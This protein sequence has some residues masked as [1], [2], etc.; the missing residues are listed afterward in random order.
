MSKEFMM[1]Q[2]FLRYLFSRAAGSLIRTISWIGLLG[3]AIGVMSMVVV[4]NVM[5]GLGANMKERLLAVEPHLIFQPPSPSQQEALLTQLTEDLNL[6]AFVF[7]EQDILV[8]TSEGFFKGAIAKGMDM[9]PLKDMLE[10]ITE[11]SRRLDYEDA[12]LEDFNLN[13]NEVIIGMGLAKSLGIFEEDEIVIVAPEVLLLPPGSASPFDQVTVV[14][15]LRTAGV[16]SKTISQTL[17]YKKGKTFATLGKTT[18]LKTGIE[19]H[20]ED[21]DNYEKYLNIADPDI[22]VESWASR[23]SDLFYSLKMEKFLIIILL[24]LTLLISS[25]AI[26]TV[27][28]LLGIEKQR[29]MGILMSLGLSPQKT[30]RLMVGISCLLSGLGLFIG[31]TLG[32]T[33][34]LILDDSRFIRLPDI[35]YDTHIPV[36]FDFVGM[37]W[38]VLLAVC[39][40]FL[41]AWIPAFLTV[42]RSPSKSLK[43]KF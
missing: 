32:I 13:D 38:I 36:K 3:I 30:R 5:N 37:G 2:F 27:L 24:S 1:G 10:R 16:D 41:S 22:S 25:F 34:S 42:E 43:N 21:P 35:Y 19:V 4:L 20:L 26:I 31:L 11:A 15:I 14:G 39:I 17:F 33:I 9:A 8:R 12:F 40:S 6:N 18:S 23:N 29:D 28:V 7:E